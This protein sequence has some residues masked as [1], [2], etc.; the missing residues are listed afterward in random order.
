MTLG[1]RIFL[2]PAVIAALWA[3]GT[4]GAQETPGTDGILS[5]DAAPEADVARLEQEAALFETI[6][7]GVALA[8][9]QCEL[10]SAETCTLTVSRDELERLLETLNQRITQLAERHAESGEATLEPVL[11]AYADAR[12]GYSR[13]LEKLATVSPPGAAVGGSE[14]PAAGEVAEKAGTTLPEAYEVFKDVDE[15]FTDEDEELP[16]DDE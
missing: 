11:V 9:A 1:L 16:D 2:Y 7:Q 4:A 8:L 13:V 5:E 14:G 10:T 6:R 12:D 3:A 15:A